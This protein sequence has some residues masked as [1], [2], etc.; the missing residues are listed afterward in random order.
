M[1]TEKSAAARPFLDFYTTHNIIPVHQ[2]TSDLENHVFR[3]NYLYRTLGLTPALLK[4][5]RALEFGPGTGDNAVATS[6][7]GLDTYAFVDGNQSSVRELRKKLKSGLIKANTTRITETNIFDF[8]DSERYDLVIAEGVIPGQ[9]RAR[10]F[11]DHISS[12][13]ALGGVVVVTTIS[14]VS[15]LSEISRNVF[16]PAFIS[17]KNSFQDQV[18]I[19]SDIFRDHLST[20][21]VS[22]RSIENWVQDNI[23][24]HWLT[25]HSQVFSLAEALDV[26]EGRYQFYNS[27]PRFCVD[28][29]WYKKVGRVSPDFN[30]LV[31]DQYH[32]FSALLLDYRNKLET[33]QRA[34]ID[35][36]WVCDLEDMSKH[37]Y[38]VHMKICSE[39]TFARIEE[40]ISILQGI[41]GILTE[42]MHETKAAIADFADGI[43]KVADGKL[44]HKFGAFRS[45]WGRGQQYASFVREA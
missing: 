35:K 22:T 36:A 13:A 42:E 10:E 30:A 8:Q 24:H 17:E 1:T 4:N 34:R 44:G 6:M 29:R 45:W 16:R 37:A 21:G 3:R 32:I 19:S 23:L 2:D 31:R 15:L 25:S 12:F 38:D 33:V 28:D 20:L 40:F 5:K 26:F 41:S 11:L 43:R 18:R 9:D 27:S 7:Y 39:N 14:Y